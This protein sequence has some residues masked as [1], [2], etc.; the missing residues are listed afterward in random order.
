M[1]QTQMSKTY[2]LNRTR[3]CF[4][5][6]SIDTSPLTIHAYWYACSNTH[7]HTKSSKMLC[8]DR[9]GGPGY[10]VEC[11]CVCVCLCVR[12]RERVDER[13]H[14]NVCECVRV[15]E[16]VYNVLATVFFSQIINRLNK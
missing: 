10:S 8:K 13:E 7:T 4:Q 2:V 9:L 6:S 11:V 16:R 5:S 14:V 1:F 3:K 12:E 15:C